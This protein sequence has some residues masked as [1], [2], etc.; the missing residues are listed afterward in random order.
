MEI[1]L[2]TSSWSSFVVNFL[3]AMA[4]HA[5]SLPVFLSLILYVVPNWPFAQF[6]VEGVTVVDVRRRSTEDGAFL[7]L[8]ERPIGV[9]LHRFLRCCWKKKGVVFHRRSSRQHERTQKGRD[10]RE[11]D[12]EKSTTEL[13]AM[14]IGES[15]SIQI[16]RHN[17]KL[18]VVVVVVVVKKQSTKKK[19][20]RARATKKNETAHLSF[21][22]GCGAPHFYLCKNKPNALVVLNEKCRVRQREKKN[23]DD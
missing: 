18:V 22:G 13:D 21:R 9:N 14:I 1:S 19:T 20:T 6:F 8:P 7:R 2:R 16:R 12:K 11:R 5:Y 10:E 17:N 3:F 4:L 15:N 23:K